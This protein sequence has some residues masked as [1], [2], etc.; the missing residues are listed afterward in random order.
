MLQTDVILEI[1]EMPF[2]GVADFAVFHVYLLV[3]C[4]CVCV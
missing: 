3:A 4:V 2:G 1:C